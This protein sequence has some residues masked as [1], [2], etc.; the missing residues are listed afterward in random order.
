MLLYFILCLTLSIH[1]DLLFEVL[2]NCIQ[3]RK[4]F[5]SSSTIENNSPNQKLQ[6]TAKINT[7]HLTRE[8]EKMDSED[9]VILPLLEH[10]QVFMLHQSAS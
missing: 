7:L 4:L 2:P 10:M 6:C 1:T 8:L 9:S 5:F 3:H